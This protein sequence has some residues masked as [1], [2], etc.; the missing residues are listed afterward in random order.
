MKKSKN[1]IICGAIASVCT[2]GAFAENEN[3]VTS[4]GYVD[5]AVGTKQNTIPAA[6]TNSAT[7]GTSV[8]MYTGTAGTIGERAIYDS[9]TYT[10]NDANKLV[11]AAS[12]NGTVNNIPTITTSKLTCSN[13]P[14]CTLWDLS[15]QTVLGQQQQGN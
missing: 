6:E 1:I 2:V 9:T 10:S 15:D 13:S 5:S 8:V 11:T 3:I 12:L 4:K 7:P 14:D